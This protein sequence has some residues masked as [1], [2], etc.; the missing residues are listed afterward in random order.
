MTNHDRSF[1]IWLFAI[2]VA[3]I[4]LMIQ[5]IA[6]VAH[7]AAVCAPVEKFL[8]QMN[9]GKFKPVW[10]GS[11]GRGFT[12]TLYQAE[13]K[14]WLAVVIAP[15]MTQACIVDTGNKGSLIRQSL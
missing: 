2:I 10:S 7:A 11:D 5:A 6:S 15:D 12:T 3:I 14:S 4:F 8:D 13:D 1:K 9:K